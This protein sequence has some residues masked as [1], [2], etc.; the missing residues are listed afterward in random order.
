MSRR[1]V[2]RLMSGRG[3][4]GIG[5]VGGK[6]PD[7][8]GTLWRSAVNFGAAFIFTAGQRYPKQATDT[9]K[10]WRQIPLY[11]CENLNQLPF[12][13]DCDVVGV[14]HLPDAVP[15]PDFAHPKRAIYLLGAEDKGLSE[16]FLRNHCDRIVSIPT[17]FSVNVATA[18]SIVMYDRLAK[19]T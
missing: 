9:M 7:N 19:A 18:G 17:P 2:S 5:I 1:A 3:Y 10:A 4:F 8:V 15:L 13:K 6:T 12:P 11:E 16:D 14:E